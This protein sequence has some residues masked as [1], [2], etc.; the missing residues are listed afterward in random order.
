VNPSINLVNY[1]KDA[2]KKYLDFS[3]SRNF[4]L[5]LYSFPFILQKDYQLVSS[6]IVEYIKETTA[7]Q[8]GSVVYFYIIAKYRL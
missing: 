7:I 3:G 2:G 4:F 5:K 8:L 1:L 6:Q